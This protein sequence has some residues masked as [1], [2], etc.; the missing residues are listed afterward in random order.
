[1][2]PPATRP[3]SFLTLVSSILLFSLVFHVRSSA[4]E[5]DNDG[6]DIDKLSFENQRLRQAYIALQAWKS[7]IFS[8]PFNFTAN[9]NGSNV[10]SYA[11]IFCSPSPSDPTVRVV[12][13]IDLNHADIAGYLPPELGLLTDLALFHLNSNRFCGIVPETFSRMK[14]L[15]ELDVSNNRFV[16]PFPKVVLSLPSLKFL[17]LRFNEFEGPVPSKLFDKDLDAIFLNDNRFRSGIPVNLGNSPVSVLVFANNDLG[18]CIPGSI[19]KMGNTLNEII[20]MNDNLTGCL[21]ANEIGFL[22]QLSV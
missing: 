9:W 20:L 19:G 22:K 3:R 16:G 2:P 6:D 13:G 21:P 7:A 8:D 12:A 18:G 5:N 15:H 4:A 11:G 1:M 14:L 17:D 10:C